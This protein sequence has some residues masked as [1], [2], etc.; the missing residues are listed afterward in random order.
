MD[1]VFLL[2]TA[3]ASPVGCPKLVIAAVYRELMPWAARKAIS[4]YASGV[5]TNSVSLVERVVPEVL[6]P[7]K[8][9]S[10][11][12]PPDTVLT[13]LSD[14]LVSSLVTSLEYPILPASVI[15]SLMFALIPSAITGLS[16]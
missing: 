6:M 1:M 9:P 15:V 5:E 2:P 3:G 12:R 4:E 13:R 16:W 7:L 11:W 14:A 10:N 8:A